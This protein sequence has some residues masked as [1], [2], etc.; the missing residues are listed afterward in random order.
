MVIFS[1][2]PQQWSMSDDGPGALRCWGDRGR[3][4][5]WS[6]LSC[7]GVSGAFF[8]WSVHL[9]TDYLRQQGRI[10]RLHASFLYKFSFLFS[11]FSRKTL[12]SLVVEVIQGGLTV[13]VSR[14]VYASHMKATGTTSTKSI[15][16]FADHKTKVLPISDGANNIC[17]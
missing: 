12:A 7:P 3:G 13:T 14:P 5:T 8:S 17:S 15:N 4:C 6:F 11:F 16:L 1:Q 9:V 2:P 10:G